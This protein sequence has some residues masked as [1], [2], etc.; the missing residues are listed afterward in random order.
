VSLA[1]RSLSSVRARLDPVA[2]LRG[3]WLPVS[4]C[5]VVALVSLTTSQVDATLKRVVIVG[6][7]N[8]IAT[9]GLYTFVGNSGVLSFGHMSFMT[10][11]AYVSALLTVPVLI[12]HSLLSS[13][14]HFVIELHMDKLLALLVAGGAA[15]VFAIVVAL[16][17]MRL[18]GLGAGI[19]TF[20]VL[21][22][23]NVVA[24]N[25]DAITR[26]R[27]TMVGVP[28][29]TSM[30]EG[31]AWSCIA[32]VVAYLFQE[33]RIGLK[34]RGSREDEIAA[35]AIG[36][37]VFRERTIAFVLSAFFLG[38]AGALYG[39]LYGSFS[40]DAFYLTLTFLTMVML[41]IGGI[42]SLSGAVIGSIVVSAV[43]E[44]LRRIEQG[45][46]IAGLHITAPDGFQ[47][48]ALALFMLAIL[49]FRPAG[50]TGGR[51]LRLP[52]RGR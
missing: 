44:F 14:P 22:I 11:G 26:G 42:N 3:L 2:L 18:S 33:T 23:V 1:S 7:I 27:Q 41:V 28:I 8:L 45:V 31:V 30:G 34:L 21:I 37:G 46:D 51:E 4:L 6:L 49:I 52:L 43:S 20:A 29:D 39:H 24:S 36:I 12:K 9:V 13:A 5:A 17:L 38:V 35:R 16:P 25:W 47:Q 10:I 19:A 40:P 15:C 32:I 50:I 48:I